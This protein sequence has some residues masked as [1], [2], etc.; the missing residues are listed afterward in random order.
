MPRTIHCNQCHAVLNLPVS[1]AAG[2]KLKC[3]RCGLKFKVSQKEASSE[4]T[5]PGIADAATSTS[6]SS[7]IFD[8]NNRSRQLDDLPMSLSDGDLR[9]AFNLPLMSGRDLES[10]QVAS[11]QR[12]TGDAAALFEDVSPVRRK[13]TAA[14]ARRVARRC[15]FCGGLVPRGMSICSACGTDQETGHRVGLDDDFAPPP[16]PPA[17]GPPIHVLLIG[18]LC[19]AG[20]VTLAILS[21]ARSVGSGSG[22]ENA[23]WLSLALV[24]L[25]CVFASIEFIRGKSARLLLVAIALGSVVDVMALI[26]LPIIQASFD[27]PEHIVVPA[28]SADLDDADTAIRPLE[29]RLDTGRMTLGVVLL[30]VFAALVMYLLSPTVKKYVH[31]RVVMRSY[32]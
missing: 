9:D 22:L 16:P 14:D 21:A 28:N 17:P 18:G 2:K 1:I 12:E 13:K 6:A 10:S 32:D 7:P 19:A 3:P 11:P 15:S 23:S 8:V 25:F 20:G 31:S 29:D 26:A 27:A 30:F 4:S 24:A 5:A